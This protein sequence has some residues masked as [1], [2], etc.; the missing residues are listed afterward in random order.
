M[1]RVAENRPHMWSREKAGTR[2]GTSPAWGFPYSVVC[3]QEMVFSGN[4]GLG[5]ATAAETT[6]R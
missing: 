4:G 3:S 5:A 2:R 6:L 1:R